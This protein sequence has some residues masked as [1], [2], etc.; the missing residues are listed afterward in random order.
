M[1]LFTGW[2][3]SSV[4]LLCGCYA[5]AAA[6]HTLTIHTNGAGIVNRNPTN[7][8]YPQGAVV[9]LT[10]IASNGWMFV[11]W[12][13]GATGS[14][15]PLNVTMDTDKVITANFS[16]LPL[17]TLTVVV[18]GEGSVNPNGGTFQSN[19]VVSLAATPASGW[20]F[21]G[22]SGD[23]T[24][25]V[26]PV[27]VTM[28]SNRTVTASFVQPPLI[29]S[30]PH[31]ASVGVGD[32]V[33][34]SVGANGTPPLSYAWRLNGSVLSGANSTNLTVTNVQ[35]T[36]AG[37]YSLVVANA[38]GSATSQVATL[39]VTNVCIGSNV[40]TACN[41]TELRAAI[42][43]GGTVQLCCNG[44]ITLANTI[45]VTN[46][47]ALDGGPNAVT[48]S[49]NS[50]V[51]LFKVATNV[52]FELK[53]LTLADGRH[54]GTNGANAGESQPAQP[55]QDGLGGAI[56]NGGGTVRL[57]SCTLSNNSAV[58]GTGGAISPYYLSP[59]AGGAGR[60]G[61][62]FN[63]HGSILLSDVLVV[64]NSVLGGFI[65]LVSPWRGTNG[66]GR[67]GAIGSRGGSMTVT[68]SVFRG[69]LATGQID[70]TGA[71][72]SEI[73]AGHARGGALETEGT[74]LALLSSKF[75]AN[76]AVA[77]SVSFG[78]SAARP[79]GP[80]YGGA[81]FV[82]SHTAVVSRCEFAGNN[83]S[84]GNGYR[85][86]GTGEGIG[87][88][89]YNLSTVDISDTT[90]SNNEAFAGNFSS[91]NQSGKG[92]AL[93]NGGTAWVSRTTFDHNLSR[94]GQAGSFGTPGA[95]YPGGHAHGGA[96]FNSGTLS[97]TNCTLALNRAEAGGTAG[98]ASAPGGT[99]FGGGIQNAGGSVYIMNTT[100]A[101]NV[102]AQAFGSPPP[103][104]ANLANT[105]GTLA[106]RNSLVAFGL[107]FS[108]TVGGVWTNASGPIVDGGFNMSSDGSCEFNSGSSF[109][110]TDPKL[111][112][113]A[114][115]G[116]LTL[117]MALQPGSPAVDFGTAIGAPP[118]DQRGFIRPFGPGVD[119]GSYEQGSP[120]L[121]LTV[122]RSG[123]MMELSFNA[124][125]GVTYLLQRSADL[126]SSWQTHE[127]IG[128][129]GASGVISRLIPVTGT[130][131]LFRLTV[132]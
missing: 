19:T 10:A 47:V 52:T 28:N 128:P 36:H 14:A 131:T 87:G 18:S 110:F 69:N 73:T 94:G 120:P 70:G 85:H 58:G 61:A 67:G 93:F 127:T 43:R 60:G 86:S 31:S 102:V 62:V 34:F 123:S 50:A 72:G 75:I 71:T 48:I 111:D 89:I 97:A 95:S 63:D 108:N 54:T 105:N 83:A 33:T 124:E 74:S 130:C 46:S 90:F 78:S 2:L 99:A 35:V 56:Y 21:N 79:P 100:I 129:V 8:V 98:F 101:S 126:M 109:N 37:D 26:N 82:T 68:G 38:Y 53:N 92:G 49:G 107:G 5:G 1:K 57:V 15:N 84:G 91:V 117:T 11:S 42:G 122:A 9:T 65:Q 114:D 116:G 77:E 88:A 112:P 41:E 32:T 104:G 81:L 44:T 23:A 118:T 80:A 6:T 103:Q 27:S 39:T 45:E 59:T 115:N 13:G 64:S 30:Q 132:R 4:L 16:L 121:Q 55:G 40:V 24:G 25:S 106:L 3:I 17:Y 51:R 113:L 119:M 96:I 76:R 20:I 66:H 12:S 22:W 29:V 125:A 7:S